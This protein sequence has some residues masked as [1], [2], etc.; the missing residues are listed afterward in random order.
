M[1]YAEQEAALKQAAAP[2]LAAIEDDEQRAPEWLQPLF[3][4]G[5]ELLF[6]PDLDREQI[7]NAAGF[8]DP[9]VWNAMREETGQPPWNHFRDARLETSAHLLLQTEMSIAEIGRLVGYS[10]IP[11]FR[12]RL[13]TFLGMHASRYRARARRRLAR[14]GPL[15]TGADTNRYWERMQDGELTDEEAR[16][17]DAYLGRLAPASAA[18]E[19]EDAERWKRLRRTFAE[20]LVE[21][22]DPTESPQQTVYQDGQWYTLP[23]ERAE[24]LP[25]DDQRR[26]VRDAV[27]FPDGT[28]FE[29]SALSDPD[30]GVELAILGVDYLATS[31]I[32]EVDPRLLPLAWARRAR[33]RWRAGDLPGAR[34]DL[35]RSAR[36]ATGAEALPALWEAERSRIAV[37]WLQG[38]RRQALELAERSVAEYR[39]AGSPELVAALGLHAELQAATADL[40][41]ES[42][43]ARASELREALTDLQ[44]ALD[45]AAETPAT[46]A[47]DA[48]APAIEAPDA[49]T[50]DART[51]LEGRPSSR[52]RPQ[53]RGRLRPLQ[54]R[55]R[56]RL[57]DVRRAAARGGRDRA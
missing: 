17:L 38:R 46:G 31:R 15:P 5:R 23:A 48:G 21:N 50:P 25:F 55:D 16:A 43:G 8:V 29:R 35:G 28:L 44:E 3:A 19:D 37:D 32:P 2:A 9:E 49:G 54:T 42:A 41:P 39:T 57:R 53:P 18:A 40:E 47:P 10:S 52:S 56:R 45:L 13:R 34:R 36:Q 4:A 26:L 6:H 7:Q 22:L 24:V 27:W 14:A 33:G 51:R 1:S 12:R 30:R 20:G 11:S